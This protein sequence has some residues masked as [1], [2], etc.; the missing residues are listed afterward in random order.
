M[1]GKGELTGAVPSPPI[2]K[3]IFSGFTKVQ[4][5]CV[6]FS[7]SKLYNFAISFSVCREGELDRHHGISCLSIIHAKIAF[8][9]AI[10]SETQNAKQAS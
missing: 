1:G 3:R 7:K 9:R 4:N 10:S 2:K 6:A 8:S 5:F